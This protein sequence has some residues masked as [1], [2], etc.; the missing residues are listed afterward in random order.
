MSLV[1]NPGEPCIQALC[2]DRDTRQG[3][4][5]KTHVLCTDPSILLASRQSP[6]EGLSH[7]LPHELPGST[8]DAK[9]ASP[10]RS[11]LPWLRGGTCEA[12]IRNLSSTLQEIAE[13]AAK[14]IAAQQKSLD[15][16]A[17]VVLEKTAP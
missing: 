5:T 6:F 17:K 11:L 4:Q 10:G 8:H 3:K 12:L 1:N 15:F 7:S 2:K 13:S 16:Q 14:A 9:F